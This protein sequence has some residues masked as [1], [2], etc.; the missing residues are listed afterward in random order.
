MSFSYIKCVFIFL[1]GLI[2]SVA[3]YRRCFHRVKLTLT[4]GITID[5]KC[6]DVTDHFAVGKDTSVSHPGKPHV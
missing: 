2:P 3:K 5:L 1:F 4:K 6:M